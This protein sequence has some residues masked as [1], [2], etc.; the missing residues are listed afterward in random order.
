MRL[1]VNV[2]RAKL[3]SW[4]D[5]TNLHLIERIQSYADVRYH[6]N[7]WPGYEGESI[8]AAEESF[9]PDA[10]LYWGDMVNPKFGLDRF[11]GAESLRTPSILNIQ[12][13]WQT[14]AFRSEVIE[15]FK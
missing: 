8:L 1:L 15:R 5:A 13:H 12:D 10:V 14:P 3:A 4:M 6:G 2:D 9:R 11:S 7:G